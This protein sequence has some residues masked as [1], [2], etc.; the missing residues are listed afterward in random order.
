MGDVT[1]FVNQLGQAISYSYNSQ[2]LLV[3]ETFSDGTQASFSYD[4]HQDLVSM[5]DTTGTTLFSYN[6]A[7]ELTGVTY[8]DGSFITYTYNAAG[9]RTQMA[10]QSGFTVNYGYDTLGRLSEL[11]DGSSN[12]IVQYTYDAAGELSSEL[13][14][15]GTETDY[16]Y[17]KDGRV[18]DIVNLAP[19]GAVQSSYAYTY[20]LQGLPIMM[21]TQAGTFTY[22][23]DADGQLT[24]VVTPAGETV[25]YQYDA[26]GNR[27]A[28]VDGG[29]TTTYTT[30]NLNQYTQ[31]GGT[32][33]QYNA[34][35]QLHF[36]HRQHRRDHLHLQRL[37]PG[38]ERRFALQH[39]H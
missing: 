32:T 38:H 18:T 9:Q 36:E 23:Y 3:G 24:S 20:N 31:V 39:D 12:L 2:G 1:E 25:T 35:G 30:N 16:T 26:N 33:Y 8:P 4:A 29:T 22:G 10:D 15:N 5:T 13:F 37:R 19:G 17:D 14:G 7:G 27:I 21:T 34:A 28:V 6:G 11:T